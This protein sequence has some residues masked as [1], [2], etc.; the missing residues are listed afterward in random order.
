MKNKNNE[1][2]IIQPKSIKHAYF[3]CLKVSLHI[4]TCNLDH[5]CVEDKISFCLHTYFFNQIEGLV[6]K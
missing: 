4:L 6:K 5:V 2:S 3:M 1:N